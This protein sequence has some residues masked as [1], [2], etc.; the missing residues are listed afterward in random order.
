MQHGGSRASG[1]VVPE[2]THAERARTLVRQGGLSSL[3]TISCRHAGYPFGSVMPYADDEGAPLFLIS[4]MAMHT[5]NLQSN[6]KA[7]LLVTAAGEGDM[8]GAGRVSLMGDAAP[9]ADDRRE[10]ARECYLASQPAAAQWIDYDDFL[11]WQLSVL[12]VYFV[13]GF[14]VMGWV[15]ADDYRAAS[16]D[17]LMDSATGIIEHMNAD[18]AEALALLCRAAGH[19]TDEAQMTSV[20][21]LGFHVRMQTAKGVRGARIAF[22]NEVESANACRETLVA[23]VKQA[24]GVA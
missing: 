5:Q 21:R 9:V 17:P 6:G 18:H 14:G 8:L 4:T 1:P 19:E 11:L 10:A 20:D 15:S 22:S 7:T 12:D 2:P 3:S 24:R 23:M 13:G 16:P